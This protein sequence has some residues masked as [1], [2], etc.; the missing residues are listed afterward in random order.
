MEVNLFLIIKSLCLWAALQMKT[1]NLLGARTKT[2]KTRR[3][4]NQLL[5]A[6]TIMRG[7]TSDQEEKAR[8]GIYFP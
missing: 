7:K 1:S 4:I 6:S 3:T 2:T 5:A 8:N